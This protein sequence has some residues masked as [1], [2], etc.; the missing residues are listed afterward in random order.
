METK[1][2]T[3]QFVIDL[4]AQ[5]REENTKLTVTA[6]DVIDNLAAVAFANG[7]P[8]RKV[9]RGCSSCKHSRAARRVAPT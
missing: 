7:G 1:E 6:A 9:S 5:L 2:I 4:I 3:L 8:I